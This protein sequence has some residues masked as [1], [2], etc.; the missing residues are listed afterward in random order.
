MQQSRSM[1]WMTFNLFVA[2]VLFAAVLSRA[3]AADN[4]REPGRT[5]VPEWIRAKAIP[6]RTVEPGRGF[7]DM[8]PLRSVI[9]NAQV[10]ALGEATHG[11]REFFELKH[12]VIEFL[13]ARMG[14]AV[15][16]IEAN[17]PEAY[18]LNDYVLRGVGDPRTLIRG[19]YFWTWQTEEVLKLVLW[20]REF[21]SSGKGRIEFTGFD[22]QFPA[23]PMSIV[24]NYVAQHQASYLPELDGC[25]QLAQGLTAAGRDFGVATATLP[26]QLAAG[27][28]VV[29]SGYIRTEDVSDGFAGLW[30]R[31]DRNQ[32][33]SGKPEILAFDNMRDRGP[34]GTT[35]WTRYQIL[36]EVP[37]G[38][39]NIN[40]GVLH[41]GRGKVWFD[42]LA[43]ELDGVPY[44]SPDERDL[45]FAGDALRGFATAGR[46]YRWSLDGQTVNL[47]KHSLRSVFTGAGADEKKP[48]PAEV[49]RCWDRV[50]NAIAAM[51]RV[52]GG[53]GQDAKESDWALR[54]ARLVVQFADL[55]TRLS[56]RD[57]S[58]AENVRW[59]AEQNHGKKIVLWAH[60]EHVAHGRLPSHVPM[61]E[62]LKEAFGNRFVSVGLA[63]DQGAFRAQGKRNEIETFSVGPAP[64]GSVDDVF[65]SSGVPLFALDLRRAPS[66]G[67]VAQWFRAEH[68][69]RNIGSL[70]SADSPAQYMVPLILPDI[71][72]VLMFVK[73]VTVAQA[74]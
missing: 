46:A 7:A 6:L 24:R 65:A 1:N 8:E 19:M 42:S 38:A 23:V 45:R 13:A 15:F 57:G 67:P 74:L 25:I 22:M 14:F 29:L 55:R 16:S 5:A 66:S 28:K 60:N 26:V 73:R 35:P 48:E 64:A 31:V 44:D 49:A 2:L 72:D 27:K 59:I 41:A 30:M 70:F 51:R 21:N 11:S 40:F 39:M 54:N 61:G 17:M 71:F 36:M 69:M 37:S 58:M 20:M 9:G 34:R 4:V 63:F 62:Y 50:V 12:R 33:G 18:Q 10:V 43:I 53:T 52:D 56:S 47:G 32:P 68:A 3:S